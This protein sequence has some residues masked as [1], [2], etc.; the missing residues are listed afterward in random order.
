MGPSAWRGRARRRWLRA[1]EIAW[2]DLPPALLLLALVMCC[3][4]EIAT[5]SPLAQ[6]WP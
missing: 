5:G 6:V 1:P 3:G 4:L 2:A